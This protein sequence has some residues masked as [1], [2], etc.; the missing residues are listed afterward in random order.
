MNFTSENF[1]KILWNCLVINF[2]FLLLLS[3]ALF[4]ADPLYSI[5]SNWFLG[6]KA[7]FVTYIYYLVGFYKMGW[8]FFNVVPYIALWMMDKNPAEE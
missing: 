7:E 2:L 4:L 8:I 1:K 3:A 5:H 6:S